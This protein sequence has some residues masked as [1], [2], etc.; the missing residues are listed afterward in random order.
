[1]KPFLAAPLLLAAVGGCF[2]R[3]PAGAPPT[4]AKPGS[5]SRAWVPD[6][7]AILA[8]EGVSGVRSA[9]HVVVAAEPSWQAIWETIYAT[10]LPRPPL[11]VVDFM[12]HSVL[13]YGLG[14]RYASLQL[15]SV[16]PADAGS[17]AYLTETVPG[18]SCVVPAIVLTPVIAV[19]VPQKIVVRTWSLRT[20]VQ[21]C[22]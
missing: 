22:S 19:D 13:V 9:I 18:A 16:T 6:A 12:S 8:S 5:E 3:T 17:A 21:E 11:P 2:E 14:S 15:D 10:R 4:A 7:A 1:M 20:V